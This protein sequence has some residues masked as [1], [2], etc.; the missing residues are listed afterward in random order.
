MR[1]RAAIAALI[2]ALTVLL[3]GC[4]SQSGQVWASPTAKVSHQASAV[5]PFYGVLLHWSGISISGQTGYFVYKNGSQIADVAASPFTVPSLACGTTYTLG[6]AA[7]NAGGTTNPAAPGVTTTYTTPACQTVTADFFVAQSSAG[8]ADGS[9]CANAA[10]VSTLSTAT[11]WTAGNIIGLCGTITSS[12]TAQASGTSGNP[13]TVYW[14]PGAKISQAVCPSTGCFNTNS[15]TW[16][17]LDGGTNGIIE[18]T[19]NGTTL[20][21]QTSVVRGIEATNCTGCTFRNLT[22]QNMYVHTSQTDTTI[23]HQQN[24]AIDLSGSSITVSNNTI[25]D[26]GWAIN[27]VFASTTSNITISG[28]E[29]YN[30][31]HAYAM[32]GPSTS[33]GSIGPVYVYDNHFHDYSNWDTTTDA[34]HHDG[35]HCFSQNAVDAQPHWNGLYIYNNRFDGATDLSG[36]PDGDNMTSQIFIEGGGGASDTPCGDSTSVV[37][38]FN[39]ILSASEPINNG[40]LTIN[41]TLPNIVNNTI[42]GAA[43]SI[44]NASNVVFGITDPVT[45]TGA[46]VENN[47]VTSGNQLMEVLVSG[48]RFASTQPDYNIYANGGSNAFHYASCTSSSSFATWKTCVGT[49]DD[50]HSQSLSS[51]NLN[52]D[53]SPQAGSPALGAGLNLTTSCASLPSSPVNVQAAC[54]ITYAGPPA[55]GGAGSTTTGSARPAGATA[56]D[57]GAY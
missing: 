29:V 3:A 45:E 49:G 48:A 46:T 54:D 43:G 57:A 34:Y 27:E 12:I 22:I 47:V 52:S 10:A 39:N 32:Q 50:T 25:H 40:V 20:G 14:E 55:G 56:W 51:A 18:S 42:I 35:I 23:S 5:D 31:D 36:S 8:T 2:A 9:S 44:T 11:H 41:S 24:N 17:T 16:L 21:H 1:V 53:G 6:V 38:V 26:A 33:G 15:K 4:G 28:N 30:S 19:D 37:W 7:H 13:I